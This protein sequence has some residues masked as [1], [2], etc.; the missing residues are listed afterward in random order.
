MSY[1]SPTTF[2]AAQLL[3]TQKFSSSTAAR[4]LA[5]RA[6]PSSGV[7]PELLSLS[8]SIDSISQTNLDRGLLLVLMK[9]HGTVPQN[10]YPL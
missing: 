10:R 9:T 1:V 7:T 5:R 2:A 3:P 6:L 8:F 4:L